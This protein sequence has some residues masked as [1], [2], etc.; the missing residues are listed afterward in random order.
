M[1][2]MEQLANALKD[3]MRAND[4]V[5]RRTVR[6]A[7]S[8]IKMK[9]IDRGKPLDD[10]AT[11][12]ILQEEIKARNESIRDAR[13]ANRADLENAALAEISVLESFLPAQLTDAELRDAVK[14]VIAEINATSPSDMG[15]IIKIVM[16]R[17][18]FRITGDRIS[19]VV[20]PLLQ[21]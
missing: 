16:E 19:Q 5:R 17:F 2:I 7:L 21:K 6:M 10:T 12:I 20:R 4:D 15:R 13:K 9:E 1:T 14:S 18:P 11:M 3:A 8:N